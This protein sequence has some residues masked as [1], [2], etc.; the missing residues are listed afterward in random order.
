MTEFLTGVTEELTRKHTDPLGLEGVHSHCWTITAW[1]PAEP[2]RDGR[3]LKASLRM[4]LDALPDPLPAEFW[5]AERLA[6]YVMVLAG[7]VGVDID[8][9]G[10]RVR[11]RR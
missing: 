1:W 2:L 10:F 3:A 4:L 7:V 8:R 11:L 5:A 9:P 6:D